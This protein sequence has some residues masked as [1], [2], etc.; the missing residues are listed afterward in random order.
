MAAEISSISG[1]IRSCLP[2]SWKPARQGNHAEYLYYNRLQY[3][4]PLAR[5]IRAAV[6][7]ESGL[8]MNQTPPE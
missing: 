5:R 1:L 8:K 3:C 6:G 4:Y 7:P 2:L